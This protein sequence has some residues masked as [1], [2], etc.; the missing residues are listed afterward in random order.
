MNI[1]RDNFV[2]AMR[3]CT[4]HMDIVTV[5]IQ[6][7][8]IEE[9]VGLYRNVGVV[10][11]RQQQGCKTTFLLRESDPNKLVVVSLWETKANSDAWQ[12]SEAYQGWRSKVNG[13]LAGPPA[14]DSYEVVVEV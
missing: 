12:N 3:R 13:V 1:I 10:V 11:F 2:H 8:K 4:M 5:S 6:P 14:V 9:A 7:G